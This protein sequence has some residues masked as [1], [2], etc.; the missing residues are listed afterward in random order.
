MNQPNLGTS[1]AMLFCQICV[2]SGTKLVSKLLTIQSSTLVPLFNMDG[3]R[4][5]V[6]FKLMGLRCLWVLE[7][8]VFVQKY[9]VSKIEDL[10][11]SSR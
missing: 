10:R 4:E 3:H 8:V 7:A 9:S 1:H 2:P 6:S 5:E 11:P